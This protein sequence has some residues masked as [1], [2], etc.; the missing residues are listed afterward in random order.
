LSTT[1][2]TRPL[3]VAVITE[4]YPPEI[5]GVANTM[6]H[7]ATGLAARGHV[8]RVVRPRQA[9]DPGP[10]TPD[11][12]GETLVPGLP[13][14]GYRGLRLGLPVFWRLRSLW[15]DEPPDIAY[16]ATEGPLGRAALRAA[17][18]LGVPA[19]TG[20]HTQFHQ[21]SRHYGLGFL[22]HPIEASLRRFHNRSDVTLVPTAELRERLMADGFARVEVL[23]RGVDTVQF[24]PERRRPDLRSAWGCGA[25][26]PVLI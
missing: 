1:E 11:R 3:R 10:G 18:A 8:V 9:E 12:E 2:T 21:Y 13:M 25:G 14:P 16:I 22:K 24:S 19:V 15:R 7:L 6:R 26:D 5:N 23:G 17:E 20:F 4:T